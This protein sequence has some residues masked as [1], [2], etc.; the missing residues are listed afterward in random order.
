MSGN[1]LNNNWILLLAAAAL[2]FNAI[3]GVASGRAILFYRTVNR[4]EDGFLY[5]LAVLAS[6]ALGIGALL[7]TLL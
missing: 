3:M 6:G 4:S 2:L 1:F 7:A 5:W